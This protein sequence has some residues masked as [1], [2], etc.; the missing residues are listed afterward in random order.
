MPPKRPTAFTLIE[1]LIVIS[2]I[3]VL[4]AVLL[5]AVSR[6][7]SSAK[8][9][10]CQSNMRQIGFV[11]TTFE[12]DHGTYPQRNLQL[13]GAQAY[14]ER[15]SETGNEVDPYITS[16]KMW[17]CPDRDNFASSPYH[18]EAANWPLTGYFN[19][20]GH[21]FPKGLKTKHAIYAPPYSST[22]SSLDGTTYNLWWYSAYYPFAQDI[23]RG[24]PNNLAIGDWSDE[25]VAHVENGR[26]ARSN[27]VRHDASVSSQKY[28]WAV[29]AVGLYNGYT[30]PGSINGASSMCYVVVDPEPFAPFL[31]DEPTFMP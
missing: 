27:A 17:Y 8:Y 11:F 5:P 16:R 25:R 13:G 15:V 31:P 1:L 26:M 4:I 29:N 9:V 22:H 7:R 10:M 19:W 18:Y 23:M 21:M 6:A 20:A 24:G 12:L 3:A 28:F 2:I 14:P 30:F